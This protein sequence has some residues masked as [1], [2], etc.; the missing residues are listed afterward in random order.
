MKARVRRIATVV[1]RSHV[2]SHGYMR[3]GSSSSS[4]WRWPD[5]SDSL[6]RQCNALTI[7]Y[8]L[9]ADANITTSDPLSNTRRGWSR[10]GRLGE[11]E[12]TSNER[13]VW[14]EGIATL[15]RRGLKG[16]GVIRGCVLGGAILLSQRCHGTKMVDLKNRKY[17]YGGNMRNEFFETNFLF[18]FY[19][20]RWSTRTLSAISKT[21]ALGLGKFRRQSETS[22]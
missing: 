8:Y 4:H 9:F 16:Q 12:A 3:T 1:S 11:R 10:A 7:Y 13:K 18:D 14:D 17:K 6:A 21:A 20:V 15:E 2:T 19:S 22:R 5:G